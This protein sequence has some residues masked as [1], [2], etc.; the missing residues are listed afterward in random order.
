MDFKDWKLWIILI[1]SALAI[2][3]AFIYPYQPQRQEVLTQYEQM[4]DK[5]VIDVI[6][7]VEDLEQAK[8]I[9]TTKYDEYVII[10]QYYLDNKKSWLF[11]LKKKEGD[12]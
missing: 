8:N 9:L 7:Q 2:G 10:E 6:V 12:K 4:Q 11:K 1:T 3:L 5:T